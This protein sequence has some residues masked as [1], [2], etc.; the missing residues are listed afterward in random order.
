[1]CFRLLDFY[2]GAGN[3]NSGSH[4]C[5]AS[6]LLVESPHPYN[7]VSVCVCV[8]RSTLDGLLT[9]LYLLVL[10]QHASLILALANS[11]D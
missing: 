2:V 6:T 9:H 5:T 8:Q 11:P 4:V 3:P 1:M 10:S 7:M